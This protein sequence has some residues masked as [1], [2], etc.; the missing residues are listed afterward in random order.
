MD[1]ALDGHIYL[2]SPSS[3]PTLLHSECLDRLPPRE[4]GLAGCS[5]GR[6]GP[7]EDLNFHKDIFVLQ[8]FQNTKSCLWDCVES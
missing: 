6:V 5:G 1:K 3:D 2:G 4:Y 7:L 8:R